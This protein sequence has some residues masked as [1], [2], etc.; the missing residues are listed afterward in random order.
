MHT[1]Q[2]CKGFEQTKAG[3]LVHAY[4]A[5]PNSELIKSQVFSPKSEVWKSYQDPHEHECSMNASLCPDT[6]KLTLTHI[7]LQNQIVKRLIY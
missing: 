3:A 5:N 4:R 1:S 6:D 2:T 7:A